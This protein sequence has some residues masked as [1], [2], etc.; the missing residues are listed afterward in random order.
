MPAQS[1]DE[2]RGL[3]PKELTDYSNGSVGIQRISDAGSQ[4]DA[5]VARTSGD[6]I[7]RL[8]EITLILERFNLLDRKPALRRLDAARPHPGG[9]RICQSGSNTSHAD[10]CRAY[11]DAVRPLLSHI[12]VKLHH[13]ALVRI[14][15]PE[16]QGG[17]PLE[18][19]EK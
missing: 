8:S 9:M 12:V 5:R 11:A 6:T 19:I 16:M 2:R 15:L 3:L 17:V 4:A 18:P 1:R 14:Y 10:S 13:A 7:V